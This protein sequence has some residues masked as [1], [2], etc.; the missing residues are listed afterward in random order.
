MFLENFRKIL[1]QRQ[2]RYPALPSGL[3]IFA[4]G[5]IH[6]R[7]DLLQSLLQDIEREIVT[8]PKETHNYIVFLGDYIDRGDQSAQVIDFLANFNPPWAEPIFLYGNHEQIF[9]TIL[10]DGADASTIYDWLSFGGHETMKSY[11]IPASVAYSDN[12]INIVDA[13]KQAVPAD[14]V[15]FISNLH[16]KWAYGGYFFCHAGVNPHCGLDSQSAQDL[17]WIR[18]PFLKH[19]KDFGAIVVHG[20]SVSGQPQFKENR[21]GIDTGAWRSGVLTTLIIEGDDCRFMQT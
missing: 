7:M 20:H 5:D 4:I 1:R 6:G 16:L 8:G 14:H 2:S 11:G 13:L 9:E 15:R 3:R 12:A 18:D 21:I 10:T 17:I 19:R